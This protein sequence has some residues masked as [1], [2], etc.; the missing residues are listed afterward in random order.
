MKMMAVYLEKLAAYIGA[1]LEGAMLQVLAID[2]LT[3]IT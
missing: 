2:D 3:C 1:T